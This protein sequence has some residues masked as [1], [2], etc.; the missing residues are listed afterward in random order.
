MRRI[1]AW[2]LAGGVLCAQHE[3][4]Q[5]DI[6][7]GARLYL[8]LCVTCHGPEGDQVAGIDFGRGKMRRAYS[9]GELVNIIRM[10]ISG[11]GMPGQGN[12][13]AGNPQAIV[14][15][16]RSI[17]ARPSRV[18]AAGD[19]ARGKTV[20][21]TKGQCLSCHRVKGNG[22]RLGPDLT[23]VGALRRA[24]ELETSLLNPDAV[25]LPQ[26]R[27]VRVVPKNGAAITG[28][29]LNQD[30][31]TV[32]LTDDQQRLLSFPRADLREVTF[33]KTS[34]MPSYQDRLTP[35]EIADVVAYL[36]SLKGL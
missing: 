7:E 11:T 6:N 30:T 20:V 9:D 32:Q 4:P 10:G 36:A 26:H 28:R 17:A 27:F 34:A 13:R 21:E 24:V 35:Q 14:A 23:E 22:S 12:M 33:L 8:N 25:V 3:Y 2:A 31:F 18:Q 5:V 29:I 19:A 1:A 16:L 15:Y